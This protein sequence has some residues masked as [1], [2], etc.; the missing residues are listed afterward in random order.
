MLD[1]RFRIWRVSFVWSNCSGCINYT[2][3]HWRL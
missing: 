1:T 2:R 3:H